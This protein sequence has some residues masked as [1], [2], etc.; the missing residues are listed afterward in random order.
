[1]PTDFNVRLR[2]ERVRLGLTQLQAAELLGIRQQSYGELETTDK[3]PRLSTLLRLVE[4]GYRLH[5]LVP[6][7]ERA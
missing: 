4:A 6:E 5:A 7:L 3:D 2:A 1:M